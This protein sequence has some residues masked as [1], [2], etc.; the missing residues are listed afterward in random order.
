VRTDLFW[1]LP[2]VSNLDRQLELARH[3]RQR[4]PGAAAAQLMSLMQIRKGAAKD[5]INAGAL[6]EVV[7]ALRDRRIPMRTHIIPDGQ[8]RHFAWDSGSRRFV[9]A[10]GGAAGPRLTLLGPSNGL[11]RKHWNRLPVEQSTRV[12]LSFLAEIKSI[13]PSNQ[14]SYIA[15]VEHE[16]Q[17]ILISGDAGCVDFKLSRTE[18]HP[19]LL[20]AMLPLHVVQV[21][22]HAGNNAHFY[23]V[24]DAAGYPEQTDPS[25]LLLSH[26]TDD[27]FRPSA[28]FK[29]F[30]LATLRQGDDVRLLSTSRP[31]P[32]KIAEFVAAF[33]PVVGTAGDKG[34]VTLTFDGSDWEVKAH[35]VSP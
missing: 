4:A 29:S 30:L 25:L 32:D 14:L 17:G 12:A 15:R 9:I 33:H 20:A 13:T 6:H 11:V 3:I 18:Y 34:D 7:T 5:A 16:G 26:A 2:D 21:A 27:R 1:D 35:A 28:E 22:H 23:R 19:A 31:R 10:S 8:P 24:L